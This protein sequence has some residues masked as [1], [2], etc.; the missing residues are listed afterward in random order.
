[1]SM[2]V[3]TL[4]EHK[5]IFTYQPLFSLLFRP[6]PSRSHDPT[7][8]LS[9]SR[10]NLCCSLPYYTTLSLSSPFSFPYLLYFLLSY[11]FSLL[12]YYTHHYLSSLGSENAI[13]SS[14]PQAFASYRPG[15]RP[16][17]RSEPGPEAPPRAASG[18]VSGLQ[19]PAP[20][21]RRAAMGSRPGA[22]KA[23]A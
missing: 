4:E 3:C 9:L 8:F 13:A 7:L 19:G 12:H 5:G 14:S 22:C 17:E 21:G 10:I 20:A 18:G 1:M 11:L 23:P 2:S 15:R 16:G 6:C